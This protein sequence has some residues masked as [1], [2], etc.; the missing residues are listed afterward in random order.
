MNKN[1]FKFLFLLA[2]AP[3]SNAHAEW[4][5]LSDQKV[6]KIYADLTNIRVEGE[7]IYWWRLLDFPNG[8]PSVGMKS[9]T[10]LTQVDCN[11]MRERDVAYNEYRNPMGK[12]QPAMS[13]TLDPDWKFITPNSEPHKVLSSLCKKAL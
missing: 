13:Q 2:F 9:A 6:A 3:V 5:F 10:I 1:I 12:G 11:L 4:V 8:G 7:Y